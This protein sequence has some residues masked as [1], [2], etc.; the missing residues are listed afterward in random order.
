MSGVLIYFTG[1]QKH[2]VI[3]LQVSCDSFFLL[4]IFSTPLT[5]H[6]PNCL[7]YMDNHMDQ[8]RNVM[9]VEIGSRWNGSSENICR[10]SN[11]ICLVPG[12]RFEHFRHLLQSPTLKLMTSFFFSNRSLDLY[13]AKSLGPLA[14]VVKPNLS[15]C[16]PYNKVMTSIYIILLVVVLLTTCIIFLCWCFKTKNY[17]VEFLKKVLKFI[18]K[19]IWS[20]YL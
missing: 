20:P 13:F 17:L 14:I 19:K 12:R 10:N 15:G 6:C 11:K 5:M 8:V 4:K 18:P 2:L 7:F 1:D 16:F 9:F 3:Y